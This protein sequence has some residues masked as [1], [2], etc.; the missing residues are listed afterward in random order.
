[1]NLRTFWSLLRAELGATVDGYI[2]ERLP[3][4]NSLPAELPAE[5]AAGEGEGAHPAE[6]I[7]VGPLTDVEVPQDASHRHRYFRW[8]NPQVCIECGGVQR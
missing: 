1:M 6:E 5:R 7:S 4:P 3:T 2:A 8:L